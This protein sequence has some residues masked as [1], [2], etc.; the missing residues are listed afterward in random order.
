V[1]LVIV[2]GIAWVVSTAL[3]SLVVLG[4]RALALPSIP[5]PGSLVVMTCLAMVASALGAQAVGRWRNGRAHSRRWLILA[6]FLGCTAIALAG[7]ALQPWPDLLSDE[8]ARGGQ[9]RF[10]FEM[11]KTLVPWLAAALAAFA[12]LRSDPHVSDTRE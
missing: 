2:T 12:I 4:Y 3:F 5:N 1:E 7:E 11:G 10:F 6:A 9:A 8:V